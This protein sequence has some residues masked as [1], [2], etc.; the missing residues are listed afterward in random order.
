MKFSALVAS[1]LFLVSA[2][3]AQNTKYSARELSASQHS[4]KGSEDGFKTKPQDLVSALKLLTFYSGQVGEV[5]SQNG[6]CTVS[7]AEYPTGTNRFVLS[8]SLDYTNFSRTFEVSLEDSQSPLAASGAITEGLTDGSEVTY[9][10][11]L[12]YD[13]NMAALT[14]VTSKSM[15]DAQ[16]PVEYVEPACVLRY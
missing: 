9:S 6:T 1:V 2:A 4:E 14:I 12:S 5:E 16:G 10:Y 8:Y 11:N 13:P 15:V 7:A 3:S